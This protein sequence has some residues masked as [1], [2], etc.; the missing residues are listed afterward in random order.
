MTAQGATYVRSFAGS[1]TSVCGESWSTLDGAVVTMC[2]AGRPGASAVGGLYL[3]E[4]SGV[5]PKCTTTR[6][7]HREPY[8]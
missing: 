3:P 1:D 5:A 8:G 2:A 4:G 7:P 6:P